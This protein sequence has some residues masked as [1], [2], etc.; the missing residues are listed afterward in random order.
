MEVVGIQQMRTIITNFAREKGFDPLRPK[1]WRA[2]SKASLSEE[3]VREEK[4][5]GD[6]RRGEKRRKRG[7]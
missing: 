5:R 3:K 2:I 7:G 4:R 1:T 6:E